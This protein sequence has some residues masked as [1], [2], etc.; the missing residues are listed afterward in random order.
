M[1]SYACL[2]LGIHFSF[3]VWNISLHIPIVCFGSLIITN[4]WVESGLFTSFLFFYINLLLIGIYQTACSVIIFICCLLSIYIVCTTLEIQYLSTKSIFL[5]V[6]SFTIRF[7]TIYFQIFSL[8]KSSFN[9][10][11]IARANNF[12]DLISSNTF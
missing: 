4:Y 9:V 10:K 5:P 7:I 8:V 1:P 6:N 11:F 3:T 12:P 2:F